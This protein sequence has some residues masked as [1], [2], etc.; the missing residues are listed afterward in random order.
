MYQSS[1]LYFKQVRGQQV[2]HTLAS[3]VAVTSYAETVWF[4]GVARLRL[5]TAAVAIINKDNFFFICNSLNYSIPILYSYS[6]NY[7]TSHF[8]LFVM[9]LTEKGKES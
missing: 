1:T 9:C 4:S 6:I 8:N 5:T 7:S 2:Q 3:L